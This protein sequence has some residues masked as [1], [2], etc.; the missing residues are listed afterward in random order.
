[1]LSLI[2]LATADTITL[3]DGTKHTGTLVGATARSVSLREGST[4]HRYLKSKIQFN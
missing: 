2:A 3:K 1:M 4:I